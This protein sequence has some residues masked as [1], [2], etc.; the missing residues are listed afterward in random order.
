MHLLINIIRTEYL[1]GFFAKTD[2]SLVLKQTHGENKQWVGLDVV[3]VDIRMS[4]CSDL[5]QTCVQFFS[6][7]NLKWYFY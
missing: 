6:L 2:N 7:S 3:V 4:Y 5:P 1:L